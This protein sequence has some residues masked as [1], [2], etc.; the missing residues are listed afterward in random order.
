MENYIIQ[1]NKVNNSVCNYITSKIINNG[2]IIRKYASSVEKHTIDSLVLNY[3]IPINIKYCKGTQYN[4]TTVSIYNINKQADN[5][6][7]TWEL[8]S[9]DGNGHFI[10]RLYRDVGYVELEAI[11][12]LN[13]LC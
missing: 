6:I 9:D 2:K 8:H 5:G 11:E 3:A 12:E 7:S 10:V 1:W 13:F 4:F